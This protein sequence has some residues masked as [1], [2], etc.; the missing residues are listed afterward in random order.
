MSSFFY[1]RSGGPTGPQG[2]QGDQGE[3][4]PGVINWTGAWSAVTAYELND[5]VSLAGSSYICIEAHTNQT[6]PNATFWGVV[7]SKGSTGNTGPTGATGAAGSQGPAGPTGPQG[8]AGAAGAQGPTG[9]TG[10]TGAQGPAGP[11][12]STGATGAK[13]VNWLGDWDSGTAYVIGDAVHNDGAAYIATANNTNSEPPSANWNILAAQGI[14]GPAGAEGPAG[15]TGAQGA[16]GIQGT[17]GI[18]GVQGE[19]GP[20]GTGINWEG[21]W[22]AETAYQINDAVTSGGSSYVCV[23]DHTDSQPPSV[24]WEVFAAKGDTGDTG[25]AGATGA[26][27]ATGEAG[28]AG[29]QG[30]T[31]LGAWSNLTTY[32]TNDAVERNGSAYI[33]LID[34]NLDFN[35][36][37]SPSQWSLLA[38]QGAQGIQGEAGETG[39]TGEAGATGDTGAAGA[40][41]ADGRVIP[42]G[43]LT[44][45]TGVPVST[46]DQTAKTI[47]FYAPYLHGF[48]DLWNGS[49]WV[50][51]PFTQ[52]SVA[53]P[54]TDNTPFDIFGY[55]DAG[56]LALETLDWA[57]QVAR[58]TALTTQNGY[59]V[60]NGDTTRLYLGTGQTTGVSGQCEDSGANR[61]L[62]NHYNRQK[63]T[64]RKELSGSGYT[65]STNTY[66]ATNN[67]GDNRVEYVAGLGDAF[68]QGRNSQIVSSTGGVSAATNVGIG[69]SNTV[70]NNGLQ[71]VTCLVENT[72]HFVVCDFQGYA[73]AP[74]AG[75]LQA[76]EKGAG[77]ASTQ[78]WTSAGVDRG[79]SGYIEG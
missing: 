23:A 62:W 14:Q 59:L 1:S 34:D 53:V 40:D 44:L 68:I 12:G 38:S 27:G 49:A 56:Q 16:Q 54:A 24:N 58:A 26:T 17:Q 36:A 65:Y 47:V 43:R 19:E 2:P 69:W 3:T 32:Q 20:A 29:P 50:Q 48:I 74:G 18:Q 63:R 72:A 25:A 4:G 10:A 55:P 60:K 79:L 51:T 5:A 66:R 6:P 61:K 21:A 57:S 41:G 76:L 7:A 8:S 9:S 28:E 45:A 42:G 67:D 11:A 15:D 78:T 37:S 22:S 75:F 70:A 30:L 39:A 33:S 71:V 52:K 46:S 13:G 73:T 64:F 35:P 77:G 31:W